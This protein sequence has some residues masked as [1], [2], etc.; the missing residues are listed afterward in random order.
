MS[1]IFVSLYIVKLLRQRFIF[2]LFINILRVFN[3]YTKSHG[4]NL[5]KFDKFLSISA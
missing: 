4:E 3:F 5:D 2:L 1:F